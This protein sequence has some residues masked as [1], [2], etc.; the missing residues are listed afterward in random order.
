MLAVLSRPPEMDPNVWGPK[1]WGIMYDVAYASDQPNNPQYRATARRWLSLLAFL[2]PCKYCRK[3]YRTFYLEEP[4]GESTTEW[5][6]RI[7]NRVNGKLGQSDSLGLSDF[8]KRLRVWQGAAGSGDFIDFVGLLVANYRQCAV[9]QKARA[10]RTFLL[11]TREL[12]PM[13]PW[14]AEAGLFLLRLP[15]AAQYEN[16]DG[17]FSGSYRRVC[18]HRAETDKRPTQKNLLARYKRLL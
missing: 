15:T 1:L 13:L 9:P 16:L 8:I 7:K 4:F 17:W 3:S 11:L 5:V 12:L 10:F 2:L 18:R 6:W 14:D